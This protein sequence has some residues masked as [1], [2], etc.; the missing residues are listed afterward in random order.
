MASERLA[1]T[2]K[3]YSTIMENLHENRKVEQVQLSVDEYLAGVANISEE[4][5]ETV[6]S[7][8]EDRQIITKNDSTIHFS[9]I[10]TDAQYV[11]HEVVFAAGDKFILLSKENHVQG[12]ADTTDEVKAAVHHWYNETFPNISK[13]DKTLHFPI[14]YTDTQHIIHR[15]ALISLVFIRI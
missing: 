8:Y 10:Y 3:W 13:Y 12:R 11:V 15:V 5:I 6:H 1:S 4:S 14:I 2:V 7:W 9:V